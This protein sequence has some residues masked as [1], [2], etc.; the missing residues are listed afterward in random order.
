MVLNRGSRDDLAGRGCDMLNDEEESTD[1][2]ENLIR[3]LKKIAPVYFSFGNHEKVYEQRDADLK[4][5]LENAGAIVL[6][7]DYLDTRIGGQEVRIGGAAVV[8]E[9]GAVGCGSGFQRTCARRTGEASSC[10]SNGELIK[11]TQPS[12]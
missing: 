12:G 10:F 4:Q 6:E 11:G 7:K 2:V 9:H 1:V 3:E 8:E 5:K